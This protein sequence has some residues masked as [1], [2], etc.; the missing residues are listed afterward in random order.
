MKYLFNIS[1][2]GADTMSNIYNC[3]AGKN[4]LPDLYSLFMEKTKTAPL[5]PVI[6]IYDNEQ[7]N[8]RPLRK[9]LRIIR[10][11]EL[12]KEKC[13]AR[14]IGNLFVVTNHLVN[15]KEECEIEDLFTEDL[16]K[17][18]INGKTF[19]RKGKSFFE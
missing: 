9:F 15:G 18:E 4:G 8:D 5:M 7:I 1:I 17:I 3:Y 12:L 16:L 2:D 11:P 6:L 14:I 10:A 13:S 19:D